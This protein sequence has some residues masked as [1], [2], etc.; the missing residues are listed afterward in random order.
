MLRRSSTLRKVDKSVQ[1][2]LMKNKDK[3]SINDIKPKLENED[4]IF[5]LK[6]ARIFKNVNKYFGDYTPSVTSIGT[7][8]NTFYDYNK[9]CARLLYETF[10]L[11]NFI[12]GKL[13]VDDKTYEKFKI[14]N[15]QWVCISPGFIGFKDDRAVFVK[16]DVNIGK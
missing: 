1:R 16:V 12:E 15:F 4:V 7:L 8:V 9:G 14:S 11:S 3:I 5:D 13:G 2:F 6:I 10:D